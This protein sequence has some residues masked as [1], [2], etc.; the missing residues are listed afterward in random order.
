[1]D[2]WMNNFGLFLPPGA[3]PK[4]EG[5]T[6]GDGGAGGGGGLRPWGGGG[7]WGWCPKITGGCGGGPNL[8][9]LAGLDGKSDTVGTGGV[10][11]LGA[12]GS[13]SGDCLSSLTGNSSSS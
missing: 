2:D 8:T 7:I 13:G 3:L 12:T 5:G 11:A 9:G 10:A 6:G 4:N 1:M